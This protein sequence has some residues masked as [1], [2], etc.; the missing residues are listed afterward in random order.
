VWI[1][2]QHGKFCYEA[3]R[4]KCGESGQEKTD[5]ELSGEFV[6]DYMSAGLKEMAG[7]YSNRLSYEEVSL[8]LERLSGEGLLSD[9][10][11]EEL[12]VEKARSISEATV[13]ELDE[14]AAAQKPMPAIEP[15]V[16]LYDSQSEEILLLADGIQV[17]EQAS[18]RRHKGASQSAEAKKPR[19]FAQTHLVML[20]KAEGG[21]EYIS[22]LLPT[23]SQPDGCLAQQVQ[24]QIIDEYG[25][26]ETP[27]KLVAITDGAATLRLLLLSI[28]GMVVTVILDWYH[29]EKKVSELMSMIARN[30]A[31]KEQHLQAILAYLWRGLT[32]QA[33]AYLLTFEARNPLQLLALQTYLQ[34]HRSE[35]IDYQRRQQAG[36]VIGSGRMEKGCDLVIGHRQKKKGMSWSLVGSRALA[37]LKVAELNGRWQQLWFSQ[38]LLA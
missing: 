24:R 13:A 31:E 30:K 11:A 8:L 26:Q 2:S 6:E 16:D 29:L 14:F 10:K 28:F 27:L 15:A 3:Q 33:L 4:Y 38:P 5:L 32:D 20:A 7:Y 23:D 17:K 37:L 12:V 18:Q 9:Q 36:K 35:I 34:K 25:H 19:S 1:R 21:Y 22:E